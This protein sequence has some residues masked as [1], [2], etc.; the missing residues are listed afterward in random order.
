MA[1]RSEPFE[2][3]EIRHDRPSV[4]EELP[5]ALF[6]H[7]QHQLFSFDIGR[8]VRDLNGHRANRPCIAV[9][10]DGSRS[11]RRLDLGPER[12]LGA[13]HD[14]GSIAGLAEEAAELEDHE[15]ELCTGRFADGRDDRIPL[16]RRREA[17]DAALDPAEGPR[18]S[19]LFLAQATRGSMSP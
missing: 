11:V 9:A 1:A 19:D 15:R 4:H 13:F 2:R 10:A 6:R 5:L 12:P 16:P 3:T 17:G 7:R 18:V 14:V 8:K